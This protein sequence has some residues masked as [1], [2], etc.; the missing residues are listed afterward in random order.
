M[1]VIFAMNFSIDISYD[2]AKAVERGESV[3]R[4]A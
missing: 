2:F 1:V 3:K 4:E